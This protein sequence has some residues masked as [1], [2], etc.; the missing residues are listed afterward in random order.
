MQEYV[1][2]KKL[3]VYFRWF[4]RH[5][6]LF[7]DMTLDKN[8]IDKFENEAQKIVENLDVK[9]DGLMTNHDTIEKGIRQTNDEIYD[10]DE[11]ELTESDIKLEKE[12]ISSDHSSVI[13][14]KYVEDTNKPTVANKFSDMIISMEKIFSTEHEELVNP[15][16]E[17][18]FYVEDEIYLSDDEDED[19]DEI[20]ENTTYSFQEMVE[21]KKIKNIKNESRKN[22]FWLKTNLANLCKCGVEKKISYLME[23][24]FQLEKMNVEHSQLLA[25]KNALMNEFSEC[26]EISRK[27]FKTTPKNCHHKLNNLSYEIENVINGNENNPE[28]THKFVENQAKKIKENVKKLSL[29]PGEGGKWENWQSDVFLEEKMFPKLYPYGVGGFLSSNMLRQSNIGYSKYIKNRLLSADPKFCNDASYVFFSFACEG[30]NR[31]EKK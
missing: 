28:K 12:F 20:D 16:A 5:N 31:H 29:A 10:S 3:E 11:E 13:T 19:D 24:K 27:Y 6:H 17:D 8:L 22:V 4:Q 1:D 15:E 14:N 7:K 23:L 21:L 18:S 25:V 26:I 9:K 2:R 30:A